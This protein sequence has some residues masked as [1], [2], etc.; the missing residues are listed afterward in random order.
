MQTQ[1]DTS[2]V[3]TLILTVL[4]SSVLLG[5][6]T[7][8]FVSIVI[9]LYHITSETLYFVLIRLLP[10]LI[11]LIAFQAGIVIAHEKVT[12]ESDKED[13]LPIDEYTAPLYKMPIEDELPVMAQQLPVDQSLL[14]VSE[15]PIAVKE[16]P[17]WAPLIEPFAPPVEQPAYIDRPVLFSDYPYLIQEGSEIASLLEPLEASEPVE[18]EA[19]SS[20]L[21]LIEDTFDQRLASEIASAKEFSYDLSLALISIS[22]TGADILSAEANVT[23][24]LLQ[25]LAI[26]TFF[27]YLQ[28]EEIAAIL[29][30]YSYQQTQRYF[31]SL[32]DG[33]RKQHPQAAVK[34]GFSSLG[35][36]DID[37]ESLIEEARVAIGLASEQSGYSIIGYETDKNDT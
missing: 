16:E 25:K 20:Y 37:A 21:T 14:K 2:A 30:F 11:G 24:T 13:T 10:L 1:R 5:I 32:L 15:A 19:I 6:I 29:P 7:Y 23:Q 31:A 34:V 22:E 18:D 36:R 33:L 12:E 17:L 27:Y 26:S 4:I 3:R 35:V 9:P 28:D 8:V